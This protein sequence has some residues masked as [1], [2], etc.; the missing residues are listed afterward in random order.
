[1]YYPCFPVNLYYFKKRHVTFC[2]IF[3]SSSPFRL[4]LFLPDVAINWESLTEDG[5][6]L[7]GHQ[8]N[9]WNITYPNNQKLMGYSFIDSIISGLLH[10]LKY[11]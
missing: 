3:R 10:I 5:C 2:A 7:F 1:M 6:G 8:D 4:V 11:F 9:L